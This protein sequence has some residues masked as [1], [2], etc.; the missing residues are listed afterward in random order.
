MRKIIKLII[1]FIIIGLIITL[2]TGLFS[3]LD[4]LVGV[5]RW[6]Y[7]LYWLSKMVI[8][9]QYSPPLDI[10]WLNLIID[11]IIWSIIVY[12]I[13]LELVIL[14]EYFSKKEEKKNNFLK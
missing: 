14:R 10:V 13:L 9:P 3:N 6:G 4:T 5:S 11:V 8:G 2:I 12:L 1:F 7:P